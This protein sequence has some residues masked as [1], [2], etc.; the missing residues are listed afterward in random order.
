MWMIVVASSENRDWPWSNLGSE[1]EAMFARTYPAICA[2]LNHFREELQ[3]RQDQ[4]R[5]W[6][7]L[8]SCAYY[9]VFEAA[10]IVYP[11]ICKERRFTLDDRGHYLD[12]TATCIATADTYLLGL[13]N[14]E[15]VWRYITG[16]CA[17][18]GDADK[19]GRV[20]LKTFYVESIPIPSASPA[21]REAIAALAQKCLDAK[22][23]G[24]EEWEREIDE[25]VAALYGL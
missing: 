4:G 24:C 23:V 16:K 8:R 5:Y 9:D 2:H 13:L 11:D 1:A 14:S 6:W 17:V 7:E 22:G 21:D 12:A 18:L 15:P 20:R 10:K 3:K 25:R 19:R